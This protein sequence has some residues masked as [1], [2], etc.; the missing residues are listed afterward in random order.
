M[1]FRSVPLVSSLPTRSLRGC[2]LIVNQAQLYRSGINQLHKLSSVLPKRQIVSSYT[3]QGHRHDVAL[4]MLR[5][6]RGRVTPLA[7]LLSTQKA[8]ASW[9]ILT[10]R[11]G[12]VS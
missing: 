11:S 12:H 5:T 10:V 3:S 8:T 2:S 1:M 9:T 4:L 6:T 7:R